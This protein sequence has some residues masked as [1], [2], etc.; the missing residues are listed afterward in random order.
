[1]NH[2]ARRPCGPCGGTGQVYVDDHDE[3]GRRRGGRPVTCRDCGGTGT[4]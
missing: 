1:M 4:R 3:K 2:D